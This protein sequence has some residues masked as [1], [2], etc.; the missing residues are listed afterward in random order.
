MV[1]VGDADFYREV[2]NCISALQ[3]INMEVLVLD[4]M[5][6]QLRI[7]TFYTIVPG[8]HFRER[9]A[10]GDA[11]LFAA[12]LA[13]Q[14]LEPAALEE[15]LYEMQQLLPDAYY[16]EFYRGKNLY[17]Q[18]M[19]AEALAHF[20]RAL[21]LDPAAEDIPYLYSYKGCCLQGSGPLRRGHRGPGSWP[22]A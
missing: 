4:T 5:H 2:Q 10:G 7:P 1:N 13:A 21:T 12:K 16:L 20:D 14:L 9:A 17:D 3:R 18:G 15:K 11:A 19:A 8:A 6:P 22:G